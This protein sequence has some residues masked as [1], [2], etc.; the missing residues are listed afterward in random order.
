VLR[1]TPFLQLLVLVRIL[2]LVAPFL[3]CFVFLVSADVAEEDAVGQGAQEG[4]GMEWAGGA[5]EWKGEVD[6]SVSEVAEDMRSVSNM[7]YCRSYIT[8]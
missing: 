7:K 2:R 6:E 8:N 3:A 4:R 1:P 5:E